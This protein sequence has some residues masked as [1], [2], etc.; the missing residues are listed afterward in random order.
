MNIVPILV[1]VVLIALVATVAPRLIAI[2]V[3]SAT[4]VF[5]RNRAARQNA[6]LRLR[7]ARPHDA[8]D[9]TDRQD[10]CLLASALRTTMG[11]LS[12]A[13]QYPAHA[14]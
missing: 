12:L 9:A 13:S 14:F 6:A 4:A 8:W 3:L 5:T 1:I 2:S 7:G 11:R 10:Q